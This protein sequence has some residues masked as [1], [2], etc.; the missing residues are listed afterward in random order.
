LQT[1]NLRNRKKKK[2]INK[3]IYFYMAS[4]SLKTWSKCPDN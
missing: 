3:W 4:P 1:N 2:K